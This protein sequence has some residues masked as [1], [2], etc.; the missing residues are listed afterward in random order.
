MAKRIV[1]IHG[2]FNSAACWDYFQGFFESRGYEVVAESWPHNQG[3]VEKLR[4]DPDPKYKSV[5]VEEIVG[6]YEGIVKALDEPPIIMGHSFGGLT[7]QILLDRGYGSVGVAIDSAPPKGVSGITVPAAKTVL[8]ILLTPFG[9]KRLIRMSL[10]HFSTGW[11]H[12]LPPEEQKKQWEGYIV[13]TPGRP[14]FQ[15][16]LAFSN[17]VTRVNFKNN[18]RAPLLLTAGS[19]DH[20]IPSKMV[21]DN[22]QK[23]QGSSATTALK[24]FEGRTHWL[25]HEPGWEEVATYAIEWA[26][27]H[28]R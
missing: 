21:R 12:T 20:A 27:E 18:D 23:Y 8:P 19:V 1:L 7:T 4:N 9:W 25:I 13:P 16:A 28:A 6:H 3:T 2:A 10:E 22:F 14:F 17:N 15:N 24:E 26:E 11:A 5:G